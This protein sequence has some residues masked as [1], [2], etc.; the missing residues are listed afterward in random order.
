[1]YVFPLCSEGWRVPDAPRRPAEIYLATLGPSRLERRSIGA[2]KLYTYSVVGGAPAT[3]QT[4]P[5]TWGGWRPPTPPLNVGLWPPYLPV[6][7]E[8]LE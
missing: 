2:Q 7:Y 6:I 3:P 4:P 1:M 8:D 5:F